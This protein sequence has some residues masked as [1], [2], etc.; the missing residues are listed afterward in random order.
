MQMTQADFEGLLAARLGCEPP[1]VSSTAVLED[2]FG[3]DSFRRLELITILAEAGIEL[4]EKEITS[5]RTV[6]DLYD[7]YSRAQVRPDDVG[8]LRASTPV[9]PAADVTGSVMPAPR[10]TKRFRFE[11][12]SPELM[13]F[14]YRM[15]IDPDV[16]HRWKFRG[17]VPDFENFCAGF[18]AG[19]L[20]QFAVISNETRQPVGQ[21]VCY[22][23]DHV[24]RFAFFAALFVPELV[25]TGIPVEASDVFVRYLF[26]TWDLR[27]IYMEVPAFNFGSFSSGEGRQFE[28]EGIL[29]NHSYYAGRHWDQYVLAIYP[30][31]EHGRP[32]DG[33]GR[34]FTGGSSGVR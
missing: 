29:K 25:G 22:N 13:P 16:G 15:A 27:K 26:A 3:L 31:P 17:F 33:G 12:I 32:N 2:S 20:V 23:C 5:L 21:V 14:M 28:V 30:P 24:Q 8:S 10:A 11:P 9:A 4:T 7:A 34:V 19:A 18:K 6:G 1:Q